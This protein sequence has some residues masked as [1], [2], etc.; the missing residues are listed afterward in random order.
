M[1]DGLMFNARN[2]ENA[3]Q[4]KVREE[5]YL[6]ILSKDAETITDNDLEAIKAALIADNIL[7]PDHADY[8][9]TSTAISLLLYYGAM[10]T[11]GVD[12]D[13]FTNAFAIVFPE[14]ADDA[15]A[16]LNVGKF[17]SRR[18]LDIK[19]KDLANL[20]A[21]T[22]TGLIESLT[23]WPLFSL[24]LKRIFLNAAVRSRDMSGLR[25][26]VKSLSSDL[27]EASSETRDI[28]TMLCNEFYV[29]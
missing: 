14:H 23:D 9:T 4:N 18:K 28:I 3:E 16:I 21:T 1:F 10:S 8:R 24:V 12:D 11:D 22:I 26:I 2:A 19:D 6:T 17:M 27:L 7:D 15:S 13:K 25:D 5:L 20:Y 29:M